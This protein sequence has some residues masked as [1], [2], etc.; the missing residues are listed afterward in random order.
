M[1]FGFCDLLGKLGVASSECLNLVFEG[2]EG[3]GALEIGLPAALYLQI[4]HDF[5]KFLVETVN[6]V[7]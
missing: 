6:E 1:R 4:A 3:G 7:Y 5:E 2:G